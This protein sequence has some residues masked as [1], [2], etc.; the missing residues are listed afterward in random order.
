MQDPFGNEFCLV[1]QLTEDQSQ[2]AMAADAATDQQWRLAAGSGLSE[3]EFRGDQEHRRCDEH[4]EDLP[5]A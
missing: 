2:A 5:G 3:C 4:L 1:V